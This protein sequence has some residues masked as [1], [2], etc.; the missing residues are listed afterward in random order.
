MNRRELQLSAAGLLTLVA[1]ITLGLMGNLTPEAHAGWPRGGLAGAPS[2]SGGGGLDG[3]PIETSNL[4]VHGDAG[5][6]WNEQVGNNLNVVGRLGVST[7]S[8]SFQLQ[9][10]TNG[11]ASDRG[12]WL[13]QHVDTVHGAVF[14]YRKSR[15]TLA[16]PTTVQTGDYGIAMLGQFYDGTNY[17]ITSGL[18]S[19]TTGTVTTASVPSE[20]CFFTTGGADNGDPYGSSLCR[21]TVGAT[22]ITTL[23]GAFNAAAGTVTAPGIAWSA[24]ADGS[25]TGF[26]RSAANTISAAC[27]GAECFRVDASEMRVRNTVRDLNG[28]QKLMFSIVSGNSWNNQASGTVN[29]MFSI[30]NSNAVTVGTGVLLRLRSSSTT[31]MELGTGFKTDTTDSTGSPGA[32]TI[33]KISGKSAIANGAAAV[34]ITNSLVAS[35]SRCFIQPTETDTTCYGAAVANWICVAGEGSFVVTAPANC[36]A[37]TNFDWFVIQ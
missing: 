13:T 3:G 10:S 37:D 18:V 9:V 19:R 16:S 35:T 25:G 15:G 4:T 30:E 36:T 5:V 33:N 12:I 21:L 11:N 22:G 7:S 20:L 2:S 14:G 26:Y 8:P 24:D 34:T 17:L 32:A 28:D 6:D 23:T 31:H 29:P 27:N 1:L